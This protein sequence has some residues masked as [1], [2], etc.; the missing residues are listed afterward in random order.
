MCAPVWLSTGAARMRRALPLA[1]LAFA[2]LALTSLPC[3]PAWSQDTLEY[4]VK[5]AYL[6]KFAPFI[7][8]PETA[9]SSPTAP[10]TICVVGTDPFGAV[11]DRA[12]SGQR[13]GDRPLALRRMAT[14]DPEVSCQILFAGGEPQEVAAVLA[15]IKDRPVVTVTDADRPARSVIS[16]V[17]VSNHVRFD[18]DEAAADAVGIKI[19]SKLLSLAHAVNRGERP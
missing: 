14:F 7:N 13:D 15:Q 8:W 4:A 9:F 11:L 3:P 18:I 6:V 2:V 1:V 17:V 5:A 10:L 19:S 16:F 12:A